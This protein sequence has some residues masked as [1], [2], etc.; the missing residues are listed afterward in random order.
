MGQK[1][2]SPDSVRKRILKKDGPAPR[3][4]SGHNA[5]MKEQKTVRNAQ[6]GP[7]GRAS[8]AAYLKATHKTWRTMPPE[9]KEEYHQRAAME[10]PVL[11]LP[12][13]S[14]DPHATHPQSPW[15]IGSSTYPCS[16]ESIQ[17]VVKDLMPHAK[18]W[19]REAYERCQ[20]VTAPE[21]V[22]NVVVEN[23]RPQ[24]D[25]NGLRRRRKRDRTCWEA[26]PGLCTSD[27]RASSSRAFYGHL[28]SAMKRFDIHPD[29][30]NGVSLSLFIV[31]ERKRDAERA[32][33][34]EVLHDLTGDFFE[35]AFLADQPDRRRGIMSFT[36][37]EFIVDAE[38]SFHCGSHASL[39]QTDDRTLD[40]CIGWKFAKLLRDRC[41]HWHVRQLAYQDIPNEYHVVKAIYLCI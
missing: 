35:M 1:K 39:V 28:V 5:F 33:G 12:Q 32:F 38:R 41:R 13:V 3:T 18:L 21:A 23:T 10:P 25:L 17:Q 6:D 30:A 40:D 37:C 16:S 14:V 9:Q 20:V 4:K 7:K 15:R 11:R 26:H 2:N 22:A 19:L 34:R 8:H 29:R 36:R 31:F 24:L 27:P